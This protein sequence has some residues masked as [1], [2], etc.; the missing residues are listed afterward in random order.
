[1]VV[2]WVF[3]H[4]TRELSNLRSREKKTAKRIKR[5]L[6][7]IYNIR[8]MINFFCMTHLSFLNKIPLECAKKDLPLT[9][10]KAIYHWRYWSLQVRH[11]EEN[12]LFVDEITVLDFFL[13]VVKVSSRLKNGWHINIDPAYTNHA[14]LAKETIANL[15]VR[16]PLFPISNPFLA[17]CQLNFIAILIIYPDKILLVVSDIWKVFFSFFGCACSQPLYQSWFT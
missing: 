1:M 11:R 14:K 13:F 4:I 12:Q 6:L 9:W 2:C 15:K 10:F 16:K 17:E 7:I 8:K 5:N 3:W